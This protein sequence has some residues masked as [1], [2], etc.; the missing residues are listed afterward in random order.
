MKIYFL[1]PF[2]TNSDL[3]ARHIFKAT[4]YNF[5]PLRSIEDIFE[6]LLLAILIME[7]FLLKTLIK[8]L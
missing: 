2:G 7:L 5:I 1:G 6:K 4:Q 3:A 8:E